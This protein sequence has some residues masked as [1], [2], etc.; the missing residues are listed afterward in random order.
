MQR[1][2]LAPLG[3]RHSSF[4]EPGSGDVTAAVP[5][6][7]SVRSLPHFRFAASAAAGLYTPLDDLAAFAAASVGRG[8]A[9]PLPPATLAVMQTPVE[10]EETSRFRYGLGYSLMTLPSGK[11]TAGHTGSNEGWTSVIETIPSTGD[12]LVVLTNRSGAFRLYRDVMCEWLLAAAGENYPRFCERERLSWTSEDTS[13]VDGLFASASE[14][15][16]GA[17]ILVAIG[18]NVVHRKAYGSADPAT[19][20]PLTPET[21]FYLASLAKSLTAQAVLR[22]RCRRQDVP[23]RSDQPF[24]CRC[25][26]MGQGCD[27]R[28]TPLSYVRSAGLS[29]SDRL[30]PIRRH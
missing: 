4:I 27:D 11:I 16:P 21:P 5:Y 26:A 22:A 19:R 8:A 3:M 23:R 12:A 15:T 24:H 13:F 10:M 30:V 18:D 9:A 6:D 17:A 1:H 28:T 20:R 14:T 7:E 29:R 25:P 2:V